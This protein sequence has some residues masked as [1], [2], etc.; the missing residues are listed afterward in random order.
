MIKLGP[1]T[2]TRSVNL[3]AETSNRWH[4]ISASLLV[5][6]TPVTSGLSG[7]ISAKAKV[8]GTNGWTEFT[9]DLDLSLLTSWRPFLSG[10]YEL[11]FTASSLPTN[12]EVMITINNWSQS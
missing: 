5:D 10:I 8:I 6:G 2:G 11:E 12:G 9:D 3:G 7:A 4:E 1:F